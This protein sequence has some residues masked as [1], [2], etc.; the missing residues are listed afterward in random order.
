MLTRKVTNLVFI[1][2]P[3]SGKTT[4]AKLAAAALGRDM[5]DTDEIVAE[6]AT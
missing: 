4:L 3:G 2:M 1:G 5:C 6:K